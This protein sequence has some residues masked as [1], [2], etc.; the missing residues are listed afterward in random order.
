MSLYYF[1]PVSSP[2][3]I[4]DWGPNAWAPLSNL[5]LACDNE[6]DKVATRLQG[7]EV[8]INNFLKTQDRSLPSIKSHLQ[9]FYSLP[10]DS[11]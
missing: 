1:I 5:Q 11:L 3:R 10:W 9:H 7:T 8:K 2:K 4:T 6:S